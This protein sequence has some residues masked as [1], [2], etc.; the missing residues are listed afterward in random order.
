MSAPALSILFATR[1]GN[2]VLGRTL[3]A[4]AAATPPDVPWHMIVVDNG[5]SDA[6]PHIIRAFSS[7]LPLEVID[8]PI[9]GK[10]AALN[11]GIEACRGQLVVVVDDDILPDASFLRAWSGYI[12]KRTEYALFGG[13]IEPYFEQPPPDWLLKD[14]RHHALM[15]SERD[16]LEGPVEPGDIYGCNM[17]VRRDVFERGFRFDEA[18]GPNRGNPNYRMGS[19]VE[20]LRR[21]GRSGASAWFARAPL[22]GHIVRPYQ[23]AESAWV[24]RGYRCGLGRAYLML[25]EGRRMNPPRITLGDRLALRLPFDRYRFPALS[26]L[27]LARGFADECKAAGYR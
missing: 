8:H 16:L 2:A 24:G 6:T 18:I 15:F 12:G 17:A 10:N 11:A 20:F 26:A 9:A 4:F 25:K 23:W 22:V 14:R 1:D 5:S 19:E 13:R 7:R 21:V 27:H 3:Q